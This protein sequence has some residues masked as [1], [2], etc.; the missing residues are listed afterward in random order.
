MQIWPLGWEDPISWRRK[1]QPTPVFL[2]WKIPLTEEPGGPLFMGWQRVG[3]DWACKHTPI[4]V[5]AFLEKFFLKWKVVP[6]SHLLISVIESLIFKRTPSFNLAV[7]PIMT[8][9]YCNQY[10]YIHYGCGSKPIRLP[11]VSETYHAFPMTLLHMKFFTTKSSCLLHILQKS[12]E[13]PLS[14][15]IAAK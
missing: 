13:G 15:G 2:A 3:H 9:C 12:A 5:Q 10:T 7:R 6:A 1:W 14:L 11:V 8:R 4:I